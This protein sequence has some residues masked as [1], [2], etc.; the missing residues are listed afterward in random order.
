VAVVMA[1]AVAVA[2]AVAVAVVVVIPR[3]P[4]GMNRW[5]EP[6]R[7][8]ALH[9]HSPQVSPPCHRQCAMP[10]GMALSLTLTLMAQLAMG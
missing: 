3:R 7:D 1:V 4:N 8:A 6:S 5:L 10:L 2:A 9:L